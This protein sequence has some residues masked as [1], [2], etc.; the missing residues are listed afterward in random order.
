MKIIM[1]HNTYREAGGEDVVFENEKRLLQRNGHIVVPFV[2]SNL[3]LQDTYFLER[4]AIATQMI[5]SS[6]TRRGFAAILDAECPDIVHVHNT[7]MAISPSIYSACS[8]R[9][10]PVVQT[11]HNF[12]LLCPAGNFFRDGIICN[13]C[14]TQN[15]LQSVHH[16]CYRN[17]R[18][19]TAGV[20]LMLAVHRALNTWRASITSFITLTEFA[21][22]KFIAA[23]FPADR[24]V[25]KPN[26][27][28]PDP[29]ERIGPG[30]YA[31]FIGRLVEN[32]GVRVLLN[33]WK[34]IPEQYPL[35]IVGDGPE[36]S[37]LEA[38]ARDCRLSGMTFRGR[39]SREEVIEAVKGARFVIV[40][41]TLY[42][43]FPMCIVESFAC[44]TPVLCSRLGGL[45]EIVQQDLTGL[46]FNPGDSLDLAAKVEW[47][48]NHPLELWQMGRAAR[49]KYETD[50][51]AEKNYSLLM[52][53]YEQALSAC[54]SRR[55]LPLLSQPII[56]NS[57]NQQPNGEVQ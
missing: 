49:A 45:A 34:K 27:T 24:F 25:V 11:L 9:N 39:L 37:A 23:G 52:E 51:T 3:D 1:V 26:F 5:W 16:G 20:A 41:S 31:V 10:I 28:D 53:I 56:S 54:A 8:E 48:W 19:A 4:I 22:E 12:R 2:R 46:H 36:R 21:K 43:G 15:L 35:Q 55:H 33:A 30:G 47:A 14:V 42:E 38:E 17:S 57:I 13:E 40:P 50:Y 32:K 29:R 44:G 6:K 18:G 7:F